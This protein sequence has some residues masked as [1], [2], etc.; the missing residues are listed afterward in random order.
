MA[1]RG[2]G[3]H[4]GLL[5]LL[6]LRAVAGRAPVRPLGP[7]VGIVANAIPGRLRKIRRVPGSPL[8]VPF[9][10]AGVPASGIGLAELL[11]QAGRARRR[12]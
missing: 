4:P 12:G 10:E 8:E 1:V 6:H 11:R 3:L 5:G 9:D 7:A 2:R